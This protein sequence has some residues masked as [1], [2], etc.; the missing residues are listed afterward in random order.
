MQCLAQSLKSRMQVCFGG[1]G[2][3]DLNEGNAHAVGVSDVIQSGQV[4]NRA[5]IHNQ[6]DGNGKPVNFFGDGNHGAVGCFEEVQPVRGG[7]PRVGGLRTQGGPLQDLRLE[8]STN[9]QG[10][11]GEDQAEGAVELLAIPHRIEG[12]NQAGFHLLGGEQEA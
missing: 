5:D 8:G 11:L 6:F 9:G 4:Q 3:A 10:D 2:L 12:L 1:G 7:E